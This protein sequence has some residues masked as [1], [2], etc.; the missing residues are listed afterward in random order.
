MKKIIISFALAAMLS[1][2]FSLPVSAHHGGSHG[3]QTQS[4]P[5]CTVEDCEEIGNHEHDGESYCTNLDNCTGNS[6][7]Q[8]HDN[9]GS[10]QAGSR[11]RHHGGGHH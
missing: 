1:S 8:V 7:C 3:R 11:G 5:R 4:Y 10:N 6:E 9:C 2:A